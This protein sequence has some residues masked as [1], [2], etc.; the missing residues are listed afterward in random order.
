MSNATTITNLQQAL[1]MEMTAAHQYQLHAHV[2][3]D[4]GL[5]ILAEKM[6]GEMQEEMRH[7][8]V[9]I[10][11]ILFLGGTPQLE[12]Q[13]SPAAAESLEQMFSS[14]LKDETEAVDFYTQAAAQAAEV[15]DVGS[16]TLFE[17]I[18]LEEEGH[19]SWLETELS[20]LKRLGEATFSA[21][22]VSGSAGSE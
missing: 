2:L 5:D 19:K 18:L 7:S 22:Y 12:L 14:D 16:R 4:W 9:F 20:L 21:R 17:R 3:D 15:G 10:E 13:K 1:R 11:R 8:D 6:R